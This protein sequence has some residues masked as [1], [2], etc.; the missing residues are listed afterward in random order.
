[1]ERKRSADHLATKQQDKKQRCVSKR[2]QTESE[3]EYSEDE[4]DPKYKKVKDLGSFI[5][6]H[7]QPYL[8]ESGTADMCVSFFRDKECHEC[9]G[10]NE[11]DGFVCCRKCLIERDELL[12]FH[13]MNRRVWEKVRRVQIERFDEWFDNRD[14][15]ELYIVCS[16]SEREYFLVNT[17][18]LTEEESDHFEEYKF[19]FF[20]YGSDFPDVVFTRDELC[21]ADLA[22]E[23]N[24]LSLDILDKQSL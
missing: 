5:K 2:P 14:F 21:E 9:E 20:Y 4:E 18:N 6:K 3:S 1:M 15:D 11:P 22:R 12:C 24:L 17:E 19:Y 23:N 8:P 13:E 7:L 16:E 10:M